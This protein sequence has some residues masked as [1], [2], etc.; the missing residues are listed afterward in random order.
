MAAE[1]LSKV[2]D[3]GKAQEYVNMVVRR[4]HG[5][6]NHDIDA[7]GDNLTEVIY[8]ERRK[9]MFGEGHR[10]FDLVRTNKAAGTIPGFTEG[11]NEVFPIP[12][13]EIQFSNNL[14]EQNTGY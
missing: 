8:D 2:G 9:E 6:E 10:F 1:A 4:A 7:V 13:E 11:K 5:D 12:I 14:W 3:N